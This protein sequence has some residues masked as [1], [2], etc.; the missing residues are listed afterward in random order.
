M[1]SESSAAAFM[2]VGLTPFIASFLICFELHLRE[3]IKNQKFY[4]RDALS[5]NLAFTASGVAD[6]DV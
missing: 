3:L 2:R 5:R 1:G 4:R 6:P